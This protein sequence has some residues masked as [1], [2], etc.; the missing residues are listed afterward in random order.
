[1]LLYLVNSPEFDFQT[2]A[3]K[4]H[5]VFLPLAP[6]EQLPHGPE[7]ITEQHILGTAHIEEASYE[8]NDQL[9]MEW[10]KQLNLHTKDEKKRTGLE[11]VIV[12]IGDQLTVERL[13]GLFKYHAQDHTSFD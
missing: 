13:C 1:M 10:F 8:G 9:I 7:S 3:D 5:N 2:Y 4:E 12:W 11:C 6:V